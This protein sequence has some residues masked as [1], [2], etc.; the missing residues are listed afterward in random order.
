MNSINY[1]VTPAASP[2]ATQPA[3]AT[4]SEATATHATDS[5]IMGSGPLAECTLRIGSG[6]DKIR[7]QVAGDTSKFFLSDLSHSLQFILSSTL[8]LARETHTHQPGM[9]LV[10][11]NGGKVTIGFR[12]FIFMLVSSMVREDR[13]R[14][15]AKADVKIQENT[16]KNTRIKENIKKDALDSK[17]AKISRKIEEQTNNLAVIMAK[18]HNLSQ[19][20]LPS[21]LNSYQSTLLDKNIKSSMNFIIP[22]QIKFLAKNIVQA[23]S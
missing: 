23:T 12:D 16:Q 6:E 21:H 11:L 10:S 18:N 13:V 3:R 5:A 14:A 2:L 9:K 7:M 1:L 4:E 19:K 22:E 20:I 15:D 8:A 17:K